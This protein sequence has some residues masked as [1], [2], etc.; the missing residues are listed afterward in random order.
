MKFFLVTALL[1]AL[2]FVTYSGEATKPFKFEEIKKEKNKDIFNVKQNQIFKVPINYDCTY[3]N[4]NCDAIEV[5]LSTGQNLGAM[6]NGKGTINYNSDTKVF[7]V[8]ARINGILS[9]HDLSDITI[10]A[11]FAK[12]CFIDIALRFDVI[13]TEVEKYV[14]SCDR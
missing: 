10:Q 1:F 4:A 8:H 5:I 9:H 3:S 13:V 6:N 2:P 11:D 7:A 12:D 14:Y